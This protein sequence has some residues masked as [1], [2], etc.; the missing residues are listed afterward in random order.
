MALQVQRKRSVNLG[1]LITT[2]VVALAFVAQPMYGMVAG[3]VANAATTVHTT[4]LSTRNLTETRDTGHNELVQ[5]GLRVWTES[6]TS[7]DKAAGYYA[8]PGL[9]LADVSSTAINFASSFSGGRPGLQLT[10][11]RDNNGTPDGN[12]VYEPW[13][14]EVGH[15]WVNEPGFGVPAGAGYASYGTLSEYQA[16][17]PDAR[18]MAIGYSL[19][20]GV[21]GDAVITSIIAGGTT[22]T[23]GLP[24]IAPAL[25]VTSPS[26][27]EVFGGLETHS[28]QKKT[29]TVRATANHGNGLGAYHVAFNG[30]G[31]NYVY[32][33]ANGAMKDT[34]ID[35]S[36]LASG[37][38]TVVVRATEKANASNAAEVRRTVQIDNT[39]PIVTTNVTNGS[40]LRSSVDV[41]LSTA[42]EAN[43]SIANIRLLDEGGSLVSGQGYYTQSASNENSWI[44]NT[45]DVVDGKYR[46]QFSARDMVGNSAETIYRD[47]TVDN[48]A[49]KVE[50]V[51]YDDDMEGEALLY[52]VV[53]DPN[54]D[55][56]VTINDDEYEADVYTEEVDGE[57]VTVWLLALDEPLTPGTYTITVRAKDQAGNET[58]EADWARNTLVIEEDSDDTTGGG[59]GSTGGPRGPELIDRSRTPGR[60][61]LLDDDPANSGSFTT[62]FAVFTLPGETANDGQDD[63]AAVLGAQ[64]ERNNGS[65]NQLAA[66]VPTESGWKIFGLMW[67]WWLLIVAAV[68]GLIWF[69][70][71]ARRRRQ[72]DA[73]L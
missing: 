5:G 38:Y 51:D 36:S 69:I 1:R 29:I 44:F 6:N 66:A 67:Y 15:Y 64:T 14:Y 58:A 16:A 45:K 62:N 4:D 41:Q 54:A 26:D 30:A 8:T 35:T 53:D 40:T 46:L 71:A 68:A 48:T 2:A 12:L 17:N 60:L 13:A 11:D 24:V 63:N 22:F 3:K 72:E 37:N 47:I 50:I 39:K 52:G 19:G 27:N 31:K 34:V 10:V 56:F 73:A 20:S 49:P 70:A 21:K 9:K 7:T 18:I 43:P 61:S 42:G 33:P 55:V 57:S 65:S 25:N 23:F 28:L 59:S 32:Q